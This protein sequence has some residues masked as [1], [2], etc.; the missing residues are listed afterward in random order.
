MHA[1]RHTLLHRASVLEVVNS[2][3]ITGHM[4]AVTGLHQVQGDQTQGEKSQVV[5]RYEGE[6][7][8]SKKSEILERIHY[9]GVTFYRPVR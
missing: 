3:A 6:L 9:E 2:E 8:V 1:F 7:P 5:R 4:T